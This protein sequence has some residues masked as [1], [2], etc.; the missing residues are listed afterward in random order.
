MA[1]R[2]K[3]VLWSR[4]GC[5]ACQAMKA[6]LQQKGYAYENIDVEGKD[7][8]RDVLEVKYGIRHVPVVEVG[9]DG[10]YEAVTD[11][12]FQRLESLLDERP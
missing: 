12:D 6:F 3:I 10:V 2:K 8:L 1:E 9:K 4:Q 5:H 7:Y 11:S